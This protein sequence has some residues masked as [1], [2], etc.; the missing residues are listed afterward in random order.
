MFLNILSLLY[1][2]ILALKPAK[3][4]RFRL[5]ILPLSVPISGWTNQPTS[6]QIE[7]IESSLQTIITSDQIRGHPDTGYLFTGQAQVYDPDFRLSADEIF[8]QS[9]Q[10]YYRAKGDVQLRSKRLRLWG[11]FAELTADS[12]AT[13]QQGFLSTCVGETDDLPWK[14]SARRLVYDQ[15]EKHVTAYH[16]TLKFFKLPIFY[17]PYLNV[18]VVRRS[19]ILPPSNGY[20]QFTPPSSTESIRS[21]FIA[22][23]LYLNLASNYD[24]FLYPTWLEDRGIHTDGN[25]RYLTKSSRGNLQFGILPDDPVLNDLPLNDKTLYSLQ[26]Q[27][28]SKWSENTLFS[29]DLSTYSPRTYLQYLPR[30]N[31]RGL[32]PSSVNRHL[33]LTHSNNKHLLSI[34]GRDTISLQD[35]TLDS[36]QRLPEINYSY[37]IWSNGGSHVNLQSQF[38]Q[39]ISPETRPTTLQEGQRLVI[40]PSWRYRK[41]T[42]D[43]QF[44]SEI[45]AYINEYR[46]KKLDTFGR[47][48]HQFLNA[49]SHQG[50]DFYLFNT[51]NSLVN[52]WQMTLIPSIHYI[53]APYVDQTKTP[54]FDSSRYRIT[55]FQQLYNPL[56]FSG[57]DRISDANRTVVSLTQEA[58]HA[59][60]SLFLAFSMGRNLD[61]EKP[62]DG[63][64]AGS[65]LEDWFMQGSMDLNQLHF[66]LLTQ[67]EEQLKTH[68]Y[69]SANG[70]YEG[71]HATI[72]M[73]ILN[74]PSEANPMHYSS[75]G[76]S[77]NITQKW[78]LNLLTNYDIQT[79]Y[80]QRYAIGASYDDCC[81][82]T[83]LIIDGINTPNE[84]FETYQVKLEVVFKGLISLGS[85]KAKTE[86]FNQ[87]QGFE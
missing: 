71:N 33:T 60:S 49:Y 16:A 64:S 51:P 6:C 56:E 61:I 70:L 85:K 43:Y 84:S 72:R 46:L 52:K 66:S 48:Q 73:N 68:R 82:Q 76:I 83:N 62:Q 2:N 32:P 38:T 8:S 40:H 79:D 17:T 26:W 37:P 18:S 1:L 63:R 29:A 78:Q 12:T 19:G 31:G 27:N 15:Q 45:G 34:A 47:T 30:L 28:D 11:Q 65:V 5:L 80:I 20:Y 14:V 75:L 39:F 9:S 36:I 4:W 77:A 55:Q 7:T 35:E 74:D 22:L 21:R 57:Y 67:W 44:T 69:W 87:S 24:A 54:N 86:M 53:Y 25:I 41:P 58:F 50:L 42:L 81:W 59:P 3:S 23:G 13:L 10:E